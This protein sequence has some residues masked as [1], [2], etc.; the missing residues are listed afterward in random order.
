M[1]AQTGSYYEL[2]GNQNKYFQ[3]IFDGQGYTLNATVGTYGLFGGFGHGTIIKTRIST[4]LS[5]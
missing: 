2:N 1:T 3:G 5:R 4:L